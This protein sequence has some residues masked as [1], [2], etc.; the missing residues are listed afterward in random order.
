MLD[1]LGGQFVYLVE[2]IDS[3]LEDA[4]KLLAELDA[5]VTNGDIDTTRR[6]AHSLKS[7][8]ADFGAQHFSQLC[9]QLETLTRGGSLKEPRSW[10]PGLPPNIKQASA[11]LVE[12][13]KHGSID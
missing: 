13:K 4:P 5:A 11:R 1:V 3:F 9:Y 10:Q 7:N 8:G 12:I 2:V 6:I